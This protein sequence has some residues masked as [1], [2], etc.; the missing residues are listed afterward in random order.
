MEKE[1]S[2]RGHKDDVDDGSVTQ[3]KAVI[4]WFLIMGVA[5]SRDKHCFHHRDALT[6]RTA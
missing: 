3:S 6:G 2:V 5:H 1:P 4:V